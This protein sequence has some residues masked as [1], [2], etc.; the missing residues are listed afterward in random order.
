[1]KH[2]SESLEFYAVSAVRGWKEMLKVARTSLSLS[3]IN[4]VHIPIL[5]A[6]NYGHSSNEDDT[7]ERVLMRRPG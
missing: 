7:I 2:N 6:P 1:M 4:D 5:D 3:S